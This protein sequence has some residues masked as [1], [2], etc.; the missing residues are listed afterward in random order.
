MLKNTYLLI[1]PAEG[2]QWEFYSFQRNTKNTVDEVSHFWRLKS[3]KKYGHYNDS[4]KVKCRV[5]INP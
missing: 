1:L 2:F 3:T 4:R 5:Q